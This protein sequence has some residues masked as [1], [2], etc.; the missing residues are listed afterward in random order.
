MRMILVPKL[1]YT[2]LYSVLYKQVSCLSKEV[3]FQTNCTVNPLVWSRG[4]RVL[5]FSWRHVSVL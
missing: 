2:I 5:C 4:T 3:D 1:H